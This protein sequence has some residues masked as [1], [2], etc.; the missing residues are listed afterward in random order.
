MI[1]N[2]QLVYENFPAYNGKVVIP[3]LDKYQ[4]LSIVNR[5]G[6]GDITTVICGDFHLMHG[7]IA[8][9]ISH[10]SHNMTI[11]YRHSK[12]A[13]IAAKEL[14][15]IGGGMCFVE[16]G[17]VKFS[18]PLPVAGLMSDLPVQE[19]AKEIKKMDEWVEYASDNLSPM[20]LAIAILAL[21]VRPGVIITNKGII[22]GENLKFVPQVI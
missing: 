8:S 16:D 10:D 14:E 20:L 9:T 2:Q 21:P 19:I 11:V 17:E 4:F 12:D 15:R 5:Y 13:Y 22:R 1:P 18:L 3:D 7:C 6:S